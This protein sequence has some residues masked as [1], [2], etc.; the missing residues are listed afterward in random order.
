MFRP[1]LLAK[2]STLWRLAEPQ[3][4]WTLGVVTLLG[5]VMAV[6]S[7][8][9]SEFNRQ[10]NA[11]GRQEI[12]GTVMYQGQPLERGRICFACQIVDSDSDFTDVQS[13]VHNG[14]FSIPRH[15]GPVPGWYLVQIK[16]DV[17]QVASLPF[18]VESSGD[19]ALARVLS[20]SSFFVQVD[21]RRTNRFDFRLR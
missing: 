6:A 15:Q 21:N 5:A 8:G 18:T 12:V 1:S 14:V 4:I 7:N 16:S 3:T 9:L 10:S 11:R 13:P 20:P 2:A 17:G 19:T